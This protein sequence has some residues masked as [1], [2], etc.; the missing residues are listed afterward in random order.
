LDGAPLN[1]CDME[2]GP[3]GKLYF[4]TGGRG[5]Q[6]AL[7]RVS[8]KGSNDDAPTKPQL[9]DLQRRRR[10]LETLH[11]KPAADAIDVAWPDL[12]SSDPW[13][14]HAARVAVERQPVDQWESRVFAEKDTAAALNG[15]IALTRMKQTTEDVRHT[16]QTKVVDKLATAV[17]KRRLDTITKLSVSRITAL[18]FT[19][20]GRPD[21]AT[22]RRVVELVRP[23]FPDTDERLNCEVCELLVY[24]GDARSLPAAFALLADSS[25]SQ[26]TQIHVARSLA[27]VPQPWPV[28]RNRAYAKWLN[29]AR[30]FRGGRPLP[31][32][33]QQMQGNFLASLSEQQKQP[34]AT[35][36]ASLAKPIEET[37][38]I[39]PR[40]LV[41]QWELID[42][43][44]L[45]T[46]N[47]KGD[48]GKGRKIFVQAQCSR[49]HRMQNS[50]GQIGP[51]LS[52]VSKRY[53][54][55]AL[56]ESIVHPAKQIDPKYALSTYVLVNGKV[57]TGRVDG[58]NSR[59]LTLET[60]P[61]AQTKVTIRR[62]EIEATSPAKSSP[63]PSGLLNYFSKDEIRDLLTFLSHSHEE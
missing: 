50:G 45:V 37:T 33:I 2:F 15:L 62:D 58:V 4:I 56:L 39:A 42:L 11:R 8:W 59:T 5:S 31:A 30:R 47:T 16:F 3:D 40:P 18:L 32:V 26:E 20:H 7:Y 6:S 35:E 48:A 54:R 29:R 27:H 14:R 28:A 61:I 63:M 53:N 44:D 22:A 9:T 52:N 34:L 1:V 12:G 36:L 55:R 60:D 13:I 19:R 43:L 41:K 49:C 17:T 10:K 57:V 25:V 24:L 51:D 38:T 23:W 21:K 46:R